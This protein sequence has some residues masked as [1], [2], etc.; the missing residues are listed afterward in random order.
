[1]PHIS[2]KKLNKDTVHKL[3]KYIISI[4]KDTGTKTRVNIFDELLT[5][6]EKMML[7]KRIGVLFLLKKGL[8][9]YKISELLGVSSSTVARFENAMDSHKYKHTV[10]WVWKNSKEGSFDAFMESLVSIAFTGRSHSFKKF[11]DEL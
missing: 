1:M 7:A 3:E 4:I 5:K 2:K 9:I 8:S 11:V 6:T 10:D